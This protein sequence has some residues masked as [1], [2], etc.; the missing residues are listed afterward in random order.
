MINW[1][2]VIREWEVFRECF[3]ILLLI[4][5]KFGEYADVS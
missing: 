3:L 4:K 5:E 2:E 1:Q